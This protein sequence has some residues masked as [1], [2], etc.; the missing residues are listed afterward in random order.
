MRE[1]NTRVCEIYFFFLLIIIFVYFFFLVTTDLVVS[2]MAKKDVDV[3]V[4]VVF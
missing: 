1:R 4:R 2:E 3:N